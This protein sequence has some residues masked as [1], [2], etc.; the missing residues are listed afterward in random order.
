[1]EGHREEGEKDISYLNHF[2]PELIN[3]LHK[4]I[5]YNLVED[6]SDKIGCKL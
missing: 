1:M 2:T 3:N 6:T 4:K 5:S